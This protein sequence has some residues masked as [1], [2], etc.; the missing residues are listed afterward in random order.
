MR[1]EQPNNRVYLQES[2][3]NRPQRHLP[4]NP[5]AAHPESHQTHYTQTRGYG[6]TLEVRGFPGGVFGDIAGGDVEA[7]EA[8]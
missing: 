2:C 8:G 4:L 1:R 5:A 3:P 7:R 6:Q